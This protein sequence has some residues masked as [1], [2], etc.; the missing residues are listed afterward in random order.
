[1]FNDR[2]DAI[3]HFVNW[4]ERRDDTGKVTLDNYK[5]LASLADKWDIPMLLHDID[6]YSVTI[7]STHQS[8]LCACWSNHPWISGYLRK[9]MIYHV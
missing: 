1:M 6:V 9:D 3:Q 2:A 5:Q 8:C 4:L 7:V